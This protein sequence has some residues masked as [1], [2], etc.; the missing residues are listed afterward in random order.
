M[1]LKMAMVTLSVL[2]LPDFNKPF[3]LET[4][5][6]GF[7]L[8]AILMQGRRPITYFIH[9]LFVR[10]RVKPIYEREMMAVVLAV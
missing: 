10:D 7:G 8:G 1:K 3:E 9:T 4:D 2:V 6:S 5:A